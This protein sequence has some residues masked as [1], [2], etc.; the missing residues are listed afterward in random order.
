MR[1]C[2]AD[3]RVIR[4]KKSIQKAFV[5]LINEKGF[6]AVTVKDITTKAKINRG[7]FYSHYQD[8]YDLLDK[9]QE[10]FMIGMVNIAKQHQPT[11]FDIL[12]ADSSSKTPFTLAILVFEYLNENIE[13]LKAVLGQNGELNFQANFKDF[14]WK[15]LFENNPNK[16]INEENLLVPVEYL[17]SY[18]SSAFTGVVQQWLNN[19]NKQSPQEMAR[20]LSIIT[21]N[22]PYFAAGM[23]K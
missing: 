19:G 13:F 14:M 22:G 4:T 9:W 16:F 6:E 18:V 3:L 21:I 5:E 11:T 12:E 8:K 17:A 2:N 23:K 15:T 10:E 1:D 7:T 20:I